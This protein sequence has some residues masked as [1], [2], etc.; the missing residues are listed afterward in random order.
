MCYPC[1]QCGRCGKYDPRS[2][3]YT[4]PA[5]IP[6]LV[7]GGEVDPA[8]GDCRACGRTA[9]APVGARL[10]GAKRPQGGPRDGERP[11]GGGDAR[12]AAAQGGR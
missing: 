5:T 2:P 11:Q 8:P 9:F 12:D 10:Q 7:C 4:P 3:Y 1:T 6:C